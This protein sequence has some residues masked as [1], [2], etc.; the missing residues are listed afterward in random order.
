MSKRIKIWF[1]VGAFLLVIGATLFV[2][3]MT[4]NRW[5]FRKLSTIK[6]ENTSQ[7]V[8]DP[9][10]NITILADDEDIMFAPS[11]DNTCQVLCK[12]PE[13]VNCLVEVRDNTLYIEVQD[14]RAW[15]HYIGIGSNSSAITIF[16]PQKAYEAFHIQTSTGDVT[17]RDLTLT[18]LSVSVSTGDVHLSRVA[19]TR[20]I[21][22]SVSTGDV[23]MYDVTCQNLTSSGSTGD[24]ELERVLALGTIS[25]ERNTGDVEFEGCDAPNIVIETTPG[26]VDLTL[27]SGKD[28][29]IR[30]STG[31]REVPP[32]MG[33]GNCKVTTSTGDIEIEIGR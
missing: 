22:I 10:Q 23:S 28:F 13:M 7:T 12:A 8:L 26:D 27:L 18:S 11:S 3:T 19:S 17:V 16:L 24:M 15:Y 33:G 5:D 32:S 1:I 6:Y 20:D 4:I 14:N 25:V 31:E 29:D 30:T 9:F 21:T 2:V